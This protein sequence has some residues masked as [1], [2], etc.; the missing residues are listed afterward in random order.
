M[1][2]LILDMREFELKD[3]SRDEWEYTA[4]QILSDHDLPSTD[5]NIQ[6]L[7]GWIL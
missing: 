5:H 4:D 3:Y 2:D 6:T 7:V 1:G